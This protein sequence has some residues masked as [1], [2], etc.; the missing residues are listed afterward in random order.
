MSIEEQLARL[1]TD[2]LPGDVEVA[3]SGDVK[4]VEDGLGLDSV[5]L[6]ELLVR[7]EETFGI[8]IED[9]ELTLS[10]VETIG[11]LADFVRRK[12]SAGPRPTF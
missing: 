12:Q 6:L 11:S 9:E 5:N 8:T 1:L 7:V 2:I 3:P 4:L 10:L